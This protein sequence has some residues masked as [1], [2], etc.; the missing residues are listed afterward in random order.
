MKPQKKK[1]ERKKERLESRTRKVTEVLLV[2]LSVNFLVI[3]ACT[4]FSCS[5]DL[6]VEIMAIGLQ[7]KLYICF[8]DTRP[9]KD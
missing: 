6:L 2:P 8:Q 5:S 7:L 1:K 9:D 4:S 3:L